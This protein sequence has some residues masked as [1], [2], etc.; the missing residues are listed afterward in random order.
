MSSNFGGVNVTEP[1]T[2]A[3]FHQGPDSRTRTGVAV[4]ASHA[5]HANATATSRRGLFA[6]F[7]FLRIVRKDAAGQSGR[8]W[9]IAAAMRSASCS[10]IEAPNQDQTP[11]AYLEVE[12]WSWNG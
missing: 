3:A 1:S 11:G 12:D 4:F 5:T 7:G 2:L 6:N 10:F 9:C 8:S